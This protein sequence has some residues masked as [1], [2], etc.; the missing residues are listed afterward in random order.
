MPVQ[1]VLLEAWT[2]AADRVTDPDTPV[3]RVTVKV[4]VKPLSWT[5]APTI[6]F[7]PTT[8]GLLPTESVIVN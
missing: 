5:P 4:S 1:T 3:V 2:A 6:S 7:E 8:N